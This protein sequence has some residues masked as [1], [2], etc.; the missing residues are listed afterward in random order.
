MFTDEI[1]K[2]YIDRVNFFPKSHEIE[3]DRAIVQATIEWPDLEVLLVKYFGQALGITFEN[4]GATDEELEKYPRA[5]F[6]QQKK[7]LTKKYAINK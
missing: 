5:N 3:D 2:A 4:L 1:T 6:K 7:Y